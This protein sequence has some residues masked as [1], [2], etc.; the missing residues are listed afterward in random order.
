MEGYM[1][2]TAVVGVFLAAVIVWA[3]RRDHLHAQYSVWWIVVATLA[4][5][6][7]VFPSLVDLAGSALGI[8]YPPSLLFLFGIVAL[9]LKALIGDI[10]RSRARQ[11]VVR[12]AQRLAIL[13]EELTRVQEERSD[14][15]GG[16]D[17][18]S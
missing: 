11:Q 12:L 1:I 14:P 15:R 6:F 13:E 17:G 3:V 5:V 4:I 16:D 18:R 7:G 9:L 2:L 8:S 10:E